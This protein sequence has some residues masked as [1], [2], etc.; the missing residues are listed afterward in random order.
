MFAFEE[1]RAELR[2]AAQLR[3]L[4]LREGS[5][6]S[7]DLEECSRIL[8]TVFREQTNIRSA[9]RFDLIQ[10]STWRGAMVSSQKEIST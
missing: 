4:R 10:S 3:R 8:W 1:H 9:R 5:Q 7:S 2:S 6:P